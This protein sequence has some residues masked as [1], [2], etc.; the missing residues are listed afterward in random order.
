MHHK[1]TH[2]YQ[3]AAGWTLL[4]LAIPLLWW[5][6]HPARQIVIEP[7]TFVFWH[8]VVELF[9]VVVAMLVFITGYRAILSAWACSIFFWLAART[10]A[11]TALLVYA[12][13]PT[14]PDITTLKKRLALALMLATVDVLGYVRLRWPDRVPA[15][16]IPGEGLTPM[17][18]SFS[19]RSLLWSTA[20]G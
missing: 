8:S 14:V 9:A 4:A 10:L 2:P 15:L 13:L 19:W 12:W 3:S 7:M 1:Q 11:A 6:S 16:F 5:V 20:W 18:S 17:T